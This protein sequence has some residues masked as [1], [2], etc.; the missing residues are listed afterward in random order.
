M[1]AEQGR[2]NSLWYIA[3]PYSHDDP[4]VVAQ[5][6]VDVEKAVVHIANKY[7]Y[8]APFSPVLYTAELQNRGLGSGPPRGWYAFDFAFLR[9]ADRLWVLKLEGWESSIGIALEIAF[10][11]AKG[12][13]IYYNTLDEL[14][15]GEDIPF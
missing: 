14:L 10:A 6:L 1:T 7:P 15:S 5:R 12:L 9:N 4:A 3:S 13:P 2:V 8:V 11:E